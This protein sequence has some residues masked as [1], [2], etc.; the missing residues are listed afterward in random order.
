M[1]SAMEP[2]HQLSASEALPLL[3]RGEI[4]SE[5]LVRSCLDRIAAEEPR[6]GAW[7]FLDEALALSQARRVDAMRPRPPLAGLPVGVKDIIDTADM[8]TECGSPALRGRR[9]DR[10]AACVEA[11]RSAGA[12]ILGKTVT[13]ELAYFSPGKTRNP[14]DPSRTPGGSSSGSAAAVACGMVPLALGTQTAGSVIRPASFCGVVGLK[15][16]HG[17][18]SLR[19]VNPF[20]PSLDTL[21]C[22]S[23]SIADLPPLMAALGAPVAS[24]EA[25]RRPRLA[26]CRTEQWPLAAKESREAVERAAG[27]LAAA[28]AAVTEVDLGPEFAGLAAAQKTIMAV[29]AAAA[30]GEMRA[31]HQASM[32]RVL[33]EILD[34]GAAT[35]PA[36]HRA[37]RDH[38]A[39]C[40][41]LLPALFEKADALLTPSAVGEAPVG[42]AGTG[43]PAFN[44]IWT[45]LGLPCLSLPG[46]TGPSGMPV[47]IQLVGPER[48]E[49]GL[50]A[51]GDWVA[52]RR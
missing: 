37:A 13:T 5:E 42:L 14:H 28:G 39:R 23:R 19:G 22:F 34:Q 17:L 10:D 44:R 4:S 1:P 41:R 6:I 2:L 32:S 51:I 9:P 7:I 21:G 3:G 33:L 52:G 16:S 27:A 48:R 38:A 24:A 30:L 31:H 20:A 50:L 26:L 49:A 47:G 15:P 25:P 45:L 43:D 18:L 12:V 46:A 8:P 36:A 40:R 29:E 35:P 11:L